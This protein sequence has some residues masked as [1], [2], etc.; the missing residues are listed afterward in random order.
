M[1]HSEGF[2]A[3]RPYLDKKKALR[4]LVNVMYYDLATCAPNKAIET[5]G[6]IMN[7]YDAEMAA[8]SKDETFKALVSKGLHTEGLSK[9][10]QRLF[11]YLAD[12]IYLMDKMPLEDYTAYKNAASKSNEMWRV[13]RSKNDFQSWLP[14]WEECVKWSK[15]IAKLKMRPETK[16]PYDAL[17]DAYEPGN[18]VEYLDSLF[19]PLKEAIA[20]LLP[21]VLK[22]QEKHKLPEVKG[23]P[24]R[25]QEDLS[26]ALL[27]LICYDMERGALRVSA[28]PFS[29]DIA[30]YDSRLTTRYNLNDWRSN[31]FTI[32][33]E[34][35]HCLEFQY[36]G[37]KIYDDYL[38]FVATA[39]QCETHSRLVEN[40]LGRSKE[41]VPTL[42][43]YASKYLGEE[44]N[45]I[46]DED[47]YLL[48]NEVKPSLI[49]C[50]ADELTYS[51][52]IIIRYEIERDLINGAIECKDVPAIWNKKYKDYLGIDVPT[53][54]DGC[55]Q[56]VHWTDGSFGYFP[57][58]AL[59]NLYGAMIFERMEEEINVLEKVKARDF[60]SIVNWLSENDYRHD[61][62][63][64]ADWIDTIVHKPLSSDAFIRY[65]T[66]KYGE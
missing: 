52:H 65:L 19:A 45:S 63:R 60:R 38:E 12:E 13:Y 26:Y 58:Y 24:A 20:K 32:L 47:L 15:K 39:A 16:T 14:Y 44:I 46:S 3:L 17:L 11:E 62:M 36:K 43:E 1:K 10:E 8:L 4:T 29:A 9:E 53:D 35:G 2:E 41:F 61:W 33:H 54:K 51:L 23:Y 18:T 7:Q 34:G 50:D 21:I 49:R 5:Q 57:S 42:K 37:D 55:M 56:D 28:H 22:R 66:K 27:D 40:I 6:E 30:Q 59:G 48:L 31:V 64:P 25:F